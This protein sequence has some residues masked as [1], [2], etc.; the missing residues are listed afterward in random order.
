[1]HKTLLICLACVTFALN[2]AGQEKTHYQS[3]DGLQREITFLLLDKN[4]ND[5]TRQLD[6]E[7]A[8]SVT[9]LLRRLVIY[10]RAGQTSRVI[11]SL[12]QLPSAE[13]WQCPANYDLRLLIRNAAAGDVGTQRLYYERVCPDDIDGTEEFVKLWS[14]NGDLKGL[15]AWLAER[16]QR[17]DEWLMRRVQLR[18]RS[19]T[20]G[21]VLDDLAADIRANPSDGARV[22]RYLRAN[23]FAGNVKDV[24]WLADTVDVRT[25]GD[26]F[27][28]AERLR[29]YSLQ[30]GAKLLQKSLDLPFTDA[31]AKLVNDRINRYLS[32]GPAIKVNLE[33]Q[34][35]YWTKRSLAETYQRMNQS[36]AAQPLV[37]ELVSMK[38]DD[39]L[40]EDVHQ[41]AGAVQS[42]SGQRVVETKILGDETAR[43]STSEYWLERAQYYEGREEYGLERESY[44]QALVALAAKSDDSKGLNERYNVVR[45]F[46][47]FLAKEHNAKK[48]KAELDKI[49]TSELSS[50][51][52]ETDY[53]FQIAALIT[54]GELQLNTL[55][56]S[57]LAKQPSF[58]ARLLDAR[59]EWDTDEMSL[60]KGLV[61]GDEV[62]SDLKEKIWASLQLLVRHPGSTRAFCLA[63]AMT[64]SAEGQRAIPIW[65]NYIEHASLEEDKRNAISHLFTAYCQAKQWRAA[66]KFLLAQRDSLWRTLPN[67]LAEVAL[68]A[69]QQNATE[70]AMRLWRMSTNLDRRNLETLPQLAHTNARPQLLAMYLNMKKEDPLSAIP[71]L[72]LQLL[73]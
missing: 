46:A 63:E 14:D 61:N 21:E 4:I 50:A 37:E 2:A 57:L 71:D 49:L 31:D 73:R 52:S 55:R 10:A 59:H 32:V 17:N 36:L 25:A 1:M 9:S 47:F 72:A 53:A 41:L 66:E 39:I 58:L 67:A 30:A 68:V 16:S 13:N 15:D 35:R 40:L 69:A 64:D 27:Q 65:R 34:L 23:N 29:S 19:G 62:P 22:D 60:I 42:G 6:S 28:L 56:H 33:K 26:Y 43:R 38:A 20:A 8:S 24:K 12:E 44:R 54:H 5:V 45:S 48:D 3:A 7:E 70:D 18:A 11:R 51:P